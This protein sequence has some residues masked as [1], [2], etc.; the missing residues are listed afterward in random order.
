MF[1]LDYLWL[2]KNWSI[3]FPD[4]QKGQFIPQPW[5]PEL[6]S[7]FGPELFEKV[8]NSFDKIQNSF[9]KINNYDKG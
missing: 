4:F 5:S 2:W 7:I 8:D 3:S 1:L 6:S 9:I